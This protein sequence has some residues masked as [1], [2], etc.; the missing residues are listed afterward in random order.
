M[1]R[2]ARVGRSGGMALAQALRPHQHGG[3]SEASSGGAC[4]WPTLDRLGGPIVP[5]MPGWEATMHLIP[6]VGGEPGE[7]M[8]GAG[9]QRLVRFN[10]TGDTEG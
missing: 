3:P 8:P 7:T 10:H 9:T 6:S 2:G 1:F 5:A 4:T